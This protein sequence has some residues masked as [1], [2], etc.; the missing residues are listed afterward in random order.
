M[1]FMVYPL[2]VLHTV[3]P[4]RPYQR[5][6]HSPHHPVKAPYSL[7]PK[8]SQWYV[9]I[10]PLRPDQAVLCCICVGC[11]RPSSACCLV[12]GSVSER[13]RGSRLVKSACL[14]I[15]SLSS[16]GFSPNSATGITSFYPLVW[17]K[18]LHL[19]L[20][21]ADWASQRAAILYITASVIVLDLGTSP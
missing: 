21:T 12:C 7:G 6:P 14:P 3:P 8:V 16:L 9:H 11:N 5:C 17:C 1:P 2:T 19:T 18:Y 10:L 20:S 15:G 13:S 4:C